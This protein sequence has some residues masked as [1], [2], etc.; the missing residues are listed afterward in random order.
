MPVSDSVHDTLVIADTGCLI[1]LSRVGMLWLLPRVYQRLTVTPMVAQEFGEV[2]PADF[3]IMSPTISL[4]P[5]H[6]LDAGEASALALA[7]EHP[8]SRV[9]IDEQTGRAVA[10]SLGLKIT[11]TLGILT[12]AKERGLLTHIEPLITA[13]RAQGMWLSDALIARALRDADE[14]DA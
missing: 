3:T 5:D 10:Q 6:G 13:M 11:G 2:L 4:L 8:G 1:H 7:V 14:A 9:L 12:R